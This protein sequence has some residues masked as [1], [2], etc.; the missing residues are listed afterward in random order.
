MRCVYA[1]QL[2]TRY[3]EDCG[4]ELRHMQ[5]TVEQ[6]GLIRPGDRCSGKDCLDL[7]AAQLL[8]VP[9]SAV[10]S[11]SIVLAGNTLFWM[12]KQGQCLASPRPAPAATQ[13][14]S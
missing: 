8:L 4:I 5:L 1:P 13:A 7:L 10:I 9:A 3:D 11:G 2:V 14:A 12:Q 6:I